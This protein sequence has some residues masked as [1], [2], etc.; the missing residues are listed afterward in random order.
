MGREVSGS[1][2]GGCRDVFD[3]DVFFFLGVYLNFSFHFP[4]HS[5]LSLHAV[6]RRVRDRRV[7]T[8]FSPLGSR[9]GADDFIERIRIT[10]N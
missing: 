4:W 3:R 1:V 8:G 7:S 10:C 5:L 9:D 2:T 6:T